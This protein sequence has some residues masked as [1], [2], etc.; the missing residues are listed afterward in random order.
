MLYAKIFRPKMRI[1]KIWYPTDEYRQ[2]QH[3]GTA[4]PAAVCTELFSICSKF[5]LRFDFGYLT[6]TVTLPHRKVRVYQ[7]S[8]F[9]K[10]VVSSGWKMLDGKIEESINSWVEAIRR[11]DDAGKSGSTTADVSGTVVGDLR[12][13][14]DGEAKRLPDQLLVLQI[15]RYQLFDV[16]STHEYQHDNWQM[17]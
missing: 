6:L 7:A 1:I 8:I 15:R 3:I 9:Q 10:V 12:R 5:V 17:T 13:Q 4:H 16:W 14:Q 11:L 2:F